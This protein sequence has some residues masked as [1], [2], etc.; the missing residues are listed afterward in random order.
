MS[1]KKGNR[2]PWSGH[3]EVTGAGMGVVDAS[4]G[5]LKSVQAP[6]PGEPFLLHNPPSQALKKITDAQKERDAKLID[7]QA[8]SKPQPSWRGPTT[9]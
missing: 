2:V 8:K 9:K 3:W 7:L 4:A 5:K 6:E 1:N